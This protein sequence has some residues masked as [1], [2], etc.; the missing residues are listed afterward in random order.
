LKPPG[1]AV[2]TAIGRRDC[3]AAAFSMSSVG[4]G[5]TLRRFAIIA[6]FIAG[7]APA[8]GED[9]LPSWNDTSAKQAIIAFVDKVTKPDGPAYVKPE[10]RIAVFDNDGTLW[11]EWP[12]YTQG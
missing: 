6:L 2:D 3:F 11:T 1:A 7:C 10:E 9:A 12:L 4:M 5:M 8:R